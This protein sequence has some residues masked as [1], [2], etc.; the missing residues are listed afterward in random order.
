MIE[1]KEDQLLFT[2]PE[3]HPEAKLSINFQRTLRIPD[4][5]DTYLLPPGLDSFPL[6]HVDDFS[7][8]IPEKWL[9]RGGVMFPMYQSEAMWIVFDSEYPF[10]VKVATGKINA[11]TGDSLES[12]LQKEPQDYLVT[13][14]Q[15]WLD[16]YCVEKGIIRQFVAMP[17]GSGYTTEEQITQEA[18]YGGL[19]VIA[20]PMKYDVYE[21]LKHHIKDVDMRLC[22]DEV[23]SLPDMGLAPG[24][25]MKQEIYE[26]SHAISS[27]DMEHGSRCFIH[28][29]NSLVWRSITGEEPPTMSPTA[30]EYT[31]QG[32]PWFDYYGEGVKS[33]DGSKKLTK[34][35]SVADMAR[36]KGD[37]PLPENESAIPAQIINIRKGLLKN[38]VREGCF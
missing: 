27:W 24:G 9:E 2:F 21:E 36:E 12:S 11:V 13:P 8:N 37:A 34:V 19:Q 15:P 28:I 5:G 22:L 3:V 32:L 25:R 16:G 30:K 20:Y 23:L 31:A 1:L 26:D 7:K 18:E 38:Q 33:L 35:K 14:D 6:Q 10:A 4:D 29:A 17:L